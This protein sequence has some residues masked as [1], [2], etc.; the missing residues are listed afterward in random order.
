MHV[1]HIKLPTLRNVK[2]NEEAELD[3]NVGWRVSYDFVFEA[4]S[5][6]LLIRFL[7]KPHVEFFWSDPAYVC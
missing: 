6:I 1:D 3:V 5:L 2:R 7:F 4:I